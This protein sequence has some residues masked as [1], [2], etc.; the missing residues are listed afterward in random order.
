MRYL[1]GKEL[2][3]EFIDYVV[4]HENKW[5]R[6]IFRHYIRYLCYKRRISPETFGWIMEVAPSRSY[7]L[8]VSSYQISLY[9]VKKTLEFLRSKHAV[10]YVIYRVML[11]SG[12]RFEHVLKI[13]K[14]WRPDE[15]IEILNIGVE[16]RRLVCLKEKGFCRYYMGLRGSEKPCEWI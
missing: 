8:D 15:V 4:N 2:S 1:Q 11:E 16:T 9:D 3:E 7:R 5:L 14:T 12:A 13:I 10:Y 6:N